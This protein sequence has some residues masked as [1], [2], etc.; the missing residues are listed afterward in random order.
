MNIDTGMG[1]LAE[2]HDMVLELDKN[3]PTEE[4]VQH[5]ELTKNKRM[6][7]EQMKENFFVIT[8][9]FVQVEC[10]DGNIVDFL[11][12]GD[13]MCAELVQN[14]KDKDWLPDYKMLTECKFIQI[15]RKYFLRFSTLK[16]SFMELLLQVMTNKLM[17][18]F[19]DSRKYDLSVEERFDFSLLELGRCFGGNNQQYHRII[20]TFINKQKIASF[21]K[22]SRKYTAR[23]LQDLEQMGNIEIID[24]GILIRKLDF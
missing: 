20:P 11:R 4:A 12:V 22:T 24:K 6:T 7:I 19:N 17:Y 16:P 23:R 1:L 5:I 21:S 10:G 3:K 2:L 18:V 14:H 9:G 8:S 13:I 15:D